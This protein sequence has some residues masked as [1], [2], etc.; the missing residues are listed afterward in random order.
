MFAS[1]SHRKRSG[2]NSAR[3]AES[4]RLPRE[5]RMKSAAISI[6]G[7]DTTR[8]C[9]VRDI[10]AGGARISTP[11]LAELPPEFTLIYKAENLIAFG[12]IAWKKGDE[13]GIKFLRKGSM[14]QEVMFKERQKATYEQYQQSLASQQSAQSVLTQRHEMQTIISHYRTLGL[15]PTLGYTADQIKRKYRVAA[16]KV[17]P[18]LGGSVEEFQALNTAYS[19]VMARIENVGA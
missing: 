14:D 8:M 2:S 17:H 19:A 7:S 13:V 11:A 16:Q 4:R 12:K 1:S 6:D 10:N 15:D 18:D 9:T 3:G 5:E